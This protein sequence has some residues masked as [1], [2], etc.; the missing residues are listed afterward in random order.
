MIDRPD[1]PEAILE[2]AEMDDDPIVE[3]ETWFAAATKAGVPQPNAM[4]L[5]TSQSDHPSAR[6]VLLKS[7]DEAGFVFYTNYDSRKARAL[8][9]NPRAALNFTWLV[10]HRQ[11]RIEG[12][13]IRLTDEESDA[14]YATR[15][16]G[17]QLAAGISRQSEVISDRAMLE[18]AFAAAD[19]KFAGEDV[20]RPS[21][22]GGFR[23][24]PEVMEFWQGKENRLHDRIRYRREDELWVK[25][26]LSP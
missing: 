13:A 1:Y 23:V 24:R 26:R 16:R 20:P 15:P 3:F 11:I 25:E 2:P 18:S 12:S 22:W 9:D 4:V 6:T 7:F 8:E 10:L 5:A 21:H 14:Y 17:A 19:E